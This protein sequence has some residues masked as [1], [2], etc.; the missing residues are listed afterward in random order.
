M[1]LW[2]YSYTKRTPISKNATVAHNN[3]VNHLNSVYEHFASLHEGVCRF[4]QV[5]ENTRSV[6]D[7]V[8]TDAS[9]LHWPLHVARLALRSIMYAYSKLTLNLLQI[10]RRYDRYLKE[11]R[12]HVRQH[13]SALLTTWPVRPVDSKICVK[14]WNTSNQWW[15]LWIPV[16]PSPASL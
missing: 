12:A 9:T 7:G 11:V 4:G 6:L 16:L 1:V 15:Q 8:V 3:S 10:Y 2:S 5:T 13:I 14:S